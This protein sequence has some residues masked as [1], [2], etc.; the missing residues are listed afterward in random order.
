[1]Q[2]G[3]KLIPSVTRVFSSSRPIY[4]YLQAYKPPAS[5]APGNTDPIVAFVSLYSGS[6]EVLKT[7]PVAV[8]P[9][10]GSRLGMVPLSFD[11]GINRLAPG[12]YQCQVTVLEPVTSKATFWRAPIAITQ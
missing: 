6:D 2:S 12:E 10:A 1:V 8:E 3:S 7:T 4:V 5:G 11:L 9:N